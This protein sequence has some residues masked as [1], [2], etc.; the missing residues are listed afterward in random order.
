VERK[1]IRNP[2]KD[3]KSRRDS[4]HQ[5]NWKRHITGRILGWNV[6][7]FN[8][9]EKRNTN[10]I[11][12]PQL[13]HKI[14]LGA[15][16]DYQNQLWIALGANSG[17]YRYDLQTKRG[18]HYTYESTGT[19]HLPIASAFD[20][21]LDKDGNLY[22]VR[23][24][25]DGKLVRWNYKNQVF[26]IIKPSVNTSAR[27]EGESYCV[28]IDVHQNIW[29]GVVREG[30]FCYNPFEK[31]IKHFDTNSGLL[32]NNIF[33][34]EC[35]KYGNVWLGTSSGIEVLR[36]QNETFIHF[37]QSDGL[38][39]SSFEPVSTYFHDTLFFSSGGKMI[40]FEPSDILDR[41]P[42]PKTYI[43]QILI[44]DQIIDRSINN[45]RYDQNFFEF[46]F[47]A[48][49]L[50]YGK[51]FLYRYRINGLE[52]SWHY[53]G[54]LK[55]A[56]Y[57]NLSPGNYEFEVSVL[58]DGKW[59]DGLANYAFTVR[60]PY[61]LTWWFIS[62][63]IILL[64]L[65]VY[66]IIRFRISRVREIEGMRS[67]ISRDLHDDIGSGLSSIRILSSNTKT[68]GNDKALESLKKIQ[69]RSQNMLDKMDDIIWAINP[70]EDKGST[71]FIR[72]RE[73]ASEMTEAA[74]MNLEIKLDPSLE[75][76]HFSMDQKS[77]LFLIFKEGINNAIKYSAASNIDIEF[78]KKGTKG[79]LNIRDNGIGFDVSNPNQG[80]GLKNM[81][82]RAHEL[83]GLLAV[84]STPG[85]GTH[86][87]LVF[88]L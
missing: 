61:W 47:T 2:H 1:R 7:F 81:K 22:L 48:V 51:D 79:I 41:T 46:S 58:V 16:K 21:T 42:H 68:S 59:Q 29:F 74:G 69:M 13:E 83:N 78:H 27:F 73:H 40:Y 53:S 88:D 49:D 85:K 38:P 64:G 50:T 11:L 14:V 54:T 66:V 67:K 62:L 72:M 3:F 5:P 65:I 60:K 75:N 57:A 31:T 18:Y 26:E 34:L 43:Y 87:N 4:F 8:E 33:A 36:A 82:D 19:Y 77:N 76:V 35:D 86:I 52:D 30:L 9:R 12:P 25:I 6:S 37:T 20:L 55:S 63:C 32:S 45:F 70:S 10:N 24:K 23:G 44:N 56:V 80:N 71:L 39:V 84:E 17:I 15:I 28:D